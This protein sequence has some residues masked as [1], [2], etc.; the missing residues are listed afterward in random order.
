MR[1]PEFYE[2]DTTEEVIIG[3]GVIFNDSGEDEPFLVD[4]EEEAERIYDEQ[5]AY[6]V[7]YYGVGFYEYGTP[8]F[9]K[10]K[11]QL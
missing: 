7:G 5:Y 3:I 9:E 2:G 8:E 6:A 1:I 4:S 10:Y 11:E